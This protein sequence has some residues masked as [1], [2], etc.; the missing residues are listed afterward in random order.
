MHTQAPLQWKLT[1][2]GVQYALVVKSPHAVRKWLVAFDD[3]IEGLSIVSKT[4]P[5]LIDV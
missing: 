2:G 4:S 1:F 3:K 5:G